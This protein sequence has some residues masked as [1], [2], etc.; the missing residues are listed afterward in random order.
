MAFA[1]NFDSI[2]ITEFGVGS[3]NG[4]GRTFSLVAVDEKVQKAL[5]EMVEATREQLNKAGANPAQYEPSDKYASLEHLIVPLDDDL[6]ESLKTLH[7]TNNYP[8]DC[9][10]LDTPGGVFCYF[11]RLQDTDGKRL[12][13][14]R[15]ASQFKSTLSKK[16]LSWFDDSLKVVERNIFRLDMDFD[17]LIDENNIHIL[18]PSGFEFVG[19]L[20]EAILAAVPTNI[21]EIKSQVD[22]IE[23]DSIQE[24]AST[25]PRAARYLASIRTFGEA[26]NISKNKLKDACAQ[27][28]VEIGEE[29]GKI[30]VD[31]KNIMGFLEILDRRRYEIELVDGEPEQFRAA[32]RSKLTS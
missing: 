17:L 26:N 27:L 23:F 28:G 5:Q 19:Q 18:R 1:F 15:R 10:T 30:M 24:Y 13:G 7:Q 4:D 12:T 8:F 22:F 25:H 6:A 2:D 21:E 11:A 14:V 16:L 9:S 31:N 29:E 20:K 3:D 32:S